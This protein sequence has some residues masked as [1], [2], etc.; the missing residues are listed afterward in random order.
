MRYLSAIIFFLFQLAGTSIPAQ[1]VFSPRAEGLP[2]SLPFKLYD[3]SLHDTIEIDVL[4][5]YIGPVELMQGGAV[6]HRIRQPY[7]LVD[8]DKPASMRIGLP[9]G[10]QFDRIRFGLGVD[11]LTSV[12]GVFPDDLDPVN[13]MYWTWQ[14]GYINFKMEGSSS[15]INT[16]NGRFQ[17]HVGGYLPPFN[18]YRILQVPAGR[19]GL[20]EVQFDL[21]GLLGQI[22]LAEN[23]VL[24]TPGKA[25]VEFADRLAFYFRGTH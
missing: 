23:P 12:S 7:F 6:V 19:G 5:F 9:A 11:S 14:S 24:M 4:R 25:A 17:F 3:S 8:A 1:L 21:A 22:R 2:V 10:L 16:A 18:T 13:G 20:T 15:K